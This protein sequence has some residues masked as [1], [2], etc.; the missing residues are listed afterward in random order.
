VAHLPPPGDAFLY[1]LKWVNPAMN[2]EGVEGLRGE[3]PWDDDRD[4]DIVAMLNKP[5]SPAG[6]T[7]FREP[8]NPDELEYGNVQLTPSVFRQ[9]NRIRDRKRS[10]VKR[11]AAPV[12][13]AHKQTETEVSL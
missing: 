12:T 4:A 1:S 8:L 7:W 9:G 13:N 11:N 2:R 3:E 6:E 10:P 5:R